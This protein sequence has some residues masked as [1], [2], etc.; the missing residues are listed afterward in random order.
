MY[1]LLPLDSRAVKKFK[2]VNR[3]MAPA[4]F[5]LDWDKWV[6]WPDPASFCVSGTTHTMTPVVS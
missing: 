4:P 6:A 1:G 3:G 2:L 5:K